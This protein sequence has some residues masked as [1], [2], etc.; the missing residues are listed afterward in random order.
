M[1]RTTGSMAPVPSMAY[2]SQEG[3]K[4]D[5]LATVKVDIDVVQR[6]QHG[7][8]G[9]ARSDVAAVGAAQP[10]GDSAQRQVKYPWTF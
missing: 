4:K 9:E 6:R 5:L 2:A 10:V 1:A 7:V 8:E 3:P